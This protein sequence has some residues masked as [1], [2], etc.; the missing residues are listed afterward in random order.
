MNIMKNNYIPCLAAFIAMGLISSC[1][2]NDF[3]DT[4]TTTV[5]GEISKILVTV[6]GM[7]EDAAGTRLD[8][9]LDSEGIPDFKFQNGDTLGI[10]P[11]VGD[12]VNFPLVDPSGKS[13]EFNGGG[14]GLKDKSAYASYFP[15]SK[16]NYW[17]SNETI[18]MN[19]L[20]QEQNGLNNPSHI[21]AYDFMATGMVYPEN[22]FLSISL[23]HMA[24]MVWMYLTIPETGTYNSVTITADGAD[25]ITEANLNINSTE[26]SMTKALTAKSI[27]MGLNS[28]TTTSAN[29]QVQ[30]FMMAAP[31]DLSGKTLTVFLKNSAGKKFKGVMTGIS[32]K[33]K[34]QIWGAQSRRKY[35]AT[36]TAVEVDNQVTENNPSAIS[37]K[38]EN[39]LEGEA[40][41]QNQTFTIDIKGQITSQTGDN[42]ITIPQVENAN[43]ELNFAETPTGTSSANPLSI[44]AKAED[45]PDG[46]GVAESWNEMTVSVPTTSSDVY[47]NIDT[48]V[49]TVKLE[50]SYEEVTARTA[51]NT[52]KIAAGTVIEKLVIAGGNV[53]IENGAKV[54]SIVRSN[55]NTDAVTKINISDGY[56]K[57]NLGNID[58]LRKDG[59]FSV[60]NAV[61]LIELSTLQKI[62]DR[63]GGS[64]WIEK[65]D[66]SQ[67]VSTWPGI[68]VDNGTVVS[69]ILKGN[70]LKGDISFVAWNNLPNLRELILYQNSSLKGELLNSGIENLTNLEALSL[71]END[72]SGSLPADFS[73]LKNLKLLDLSNNNF[74]GSIPTSWYSLKLEVLDLSDNQLTISQSDAALKNWLN[75]ISYT[76]IDNQSAAE[77]GVNASIEPF[78]ES[79]YD[80]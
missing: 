55:S 37:E 5:G 40:G 53:E 38:L 10:F 14:W 22:D 50:G 57:N 20:G 23:K 27:S 1:S 21:G 12:Q 32:D 18:I 17:R 2:S 47:V 64:D 73:N 30:I 70:N 56:N 3:E 33:D 66:I 8:Y 52:L 39:L 63:L 65:W 79:E 24:T 77:D 59:H 67:P 36:L 54:N 76:N 28:F 16:K 41:L 61:D 19:F 35:T 58:N 29:Q 72:L 48:P 46:Q 9:S 6:E 69:L 80:W 75:S 51:V 62:Y 49:S 74:T 13:F 26:P 15:F 78:S 7:E 11:T 34:L 42:A 43:I 45:M 68:T 4:A 31:V 25:F 60:S 71:G 44:I